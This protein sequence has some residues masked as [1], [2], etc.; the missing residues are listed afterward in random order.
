M[1]DQ[2][3]QT[4]EP[5]FQATE[6]NEQYSRLTV[7]NVLKGQRECFVANVVWFKKKKSLTS[8]LFASVKLQQ[9]MV[10]KKWLPSGPALSIVQYIGN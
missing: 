1:G 5:K 6:S 3:L 4:C 7:F 9:Q 10:F 2:I 8:R